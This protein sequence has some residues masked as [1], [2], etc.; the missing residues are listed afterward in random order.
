[1]KHMRGLSKFYRV[2]NFIERSRKF[3]EK[4]KGNFFGKEEIIEK[5]RGNFFGKEETIREGR[6]NF[7]G[8]E[9]T[10]REGRG[11]IWNVRVGSK[12]TP[13]NFFATATPLL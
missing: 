10:I 5:G 13:K 3:F 4:G 9:E 7:F 8:K 12:N 2:G 11:N 6:G 1:M